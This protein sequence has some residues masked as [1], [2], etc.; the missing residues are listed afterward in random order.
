M[1][2]VHL[3]GNVWEW[4][5]SAYLPYPGF[6]RFAGVAEEYNGKFMS[7]QMVVKGGACIT[8]KDHFRTTYRN[9]FQPEK[10]WQF[11]GLRLAK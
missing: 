1:P 6:K 9:F 10:R 5:Q 4:S 3:F 8:P 11:T 2:H 7:N